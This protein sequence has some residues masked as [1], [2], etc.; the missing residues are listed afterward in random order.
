ME[1][2]D[3]VALEPLLLA[4]A[5]TVHRVVLVHLLFAVLVDVAA[6]VSARQDKLGL[7][8]ADAPGLQYA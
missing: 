1:A 3:L 6:D 7:V 5:H 4:A 2:R 8:T